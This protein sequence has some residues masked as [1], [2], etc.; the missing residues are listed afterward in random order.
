MY[1]SPQKTD[2]LLETLTLDVCLDELISNTD[3]T[4]FSNWFRIMSP[5]DQTTEA[6]GRKCVHTEKG[7][8]RNRPEG[9]IKSQTSSLGERGQ[10]K[11]GM[12][13][14]EIKSLN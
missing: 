3:G 9:Q 5:D 4:S 7:E 13:I 8:G 6:R 11:T 12:H 14:A 2:K 1:P 10:K